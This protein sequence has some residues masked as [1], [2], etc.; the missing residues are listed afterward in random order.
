MS[1]TPISRKD[2]ED[3]DETRMQEVLDAQ[4]ENQA[5]REKLVKAEIQALLDAAQASARVDPVTLQRSGPHQQV[6]RP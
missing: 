2:A 5:I 3:G 4:R 1:T 6:N